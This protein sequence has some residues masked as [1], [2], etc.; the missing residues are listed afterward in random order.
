MRVPRCSVAVGRGW[1]TDCGGWGRSPFAVCGQR[2]R[3]CAMRVVFGRSS[4]SSYASERARVGGVGDRTQ[5]EWVEAPERL[6]AAE[7]GGLW[8]NGVAYRRCRRRPT[9]VTA[10]R[11]A[12]VR[13]RYLVHERRC[14]A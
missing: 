11:G 5:G 12:A 2:R 6:V 9:L 7:Y 3:K 14:V 13:G 1:R 10:T 4:C 8:L